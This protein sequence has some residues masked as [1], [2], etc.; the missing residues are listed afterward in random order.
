MLFALFLC[1]RIEWWVGDVLCLAADVRDSH[2]DHLVPGADNL[3]ITGESPIR[4]DT[5]RS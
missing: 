1:A 5:N 2:R 4:G 3:V